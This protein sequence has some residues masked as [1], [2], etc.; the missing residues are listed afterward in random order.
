MKIQNI[1]NHPPGL[2]FPQAIVRASVSKQFKLQYDN[3]TIL[4]NS[5]KIWRYCKRSIIN[6]RGGQSHLN[7]DETMSSLKIFWRVFVPF[8][9]LH[10][11]GL[12][13]C[14]QVTLMHHDQQGFS[15]FLQEKQRCFRAT[16]LLKKKH[17]KVKFKAFWKLWISLFLCCASKLVILYHGDW[18]VTFLSS[19]WVCPKIG[20]PQNGWFIMEN[21]IKIEVIWGV[22]PPIFGNTQLEVTVPTF[23]FGSRFHSP[24]QKG[25][26]S[27][28]LCHQ[29]SIPKPMFEGDG[30]LVGRNIPRG[31]PIHAQI[32]NKNPNT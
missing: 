25:H 21:P 12:F 17:A 3:K 27:R 4:I 15:I 9:W 11:L 24:S 22:F 10:Y 5:W 19:S 29:L 7:F 31:I 6:F 13:C 20:V 26:N 14:I 1:W 23:E 18:K 8:R 32:S 16:K 28:V 2:G 30:V